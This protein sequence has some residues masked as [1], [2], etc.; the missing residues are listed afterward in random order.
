[1]LCC[2]TLC[3]LLNLAIVI[4]INAKIINILS[5]II[6][7]EVLLFVYMF[8][9]IIGLTVIKINYYDPIVKYR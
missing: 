9:I 5:N 1:M 6:N 8:G 2:R 3:N 7:S 4:S